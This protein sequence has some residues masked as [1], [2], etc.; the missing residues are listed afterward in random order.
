MLRLARA[1]RGNK[2]VAR[3]R[4]MTQ[5][6]ALAVIFF[7]TSSIHSAETTWD[8]LHRFGLGGIWAAFC[9]CHGSKIQVNLCVEETRTWKR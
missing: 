8:V 2:I 1:Y 9:A 4:D 6:I 3:L 7:W 5:A